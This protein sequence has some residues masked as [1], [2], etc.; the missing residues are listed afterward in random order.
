[1]YFTSGNKGWIQ[2][3]PSTAAQSVHVPASMCTQNTL[4]DFPLMC[5]EMGNGGNT[6]RSNMCRTSQNGC[7][8]PVFCV[9]LSAVCW[10]QCQNGGVCQRPNICSCPEG[11][12]GRLCEERKCLTATTQDSTLLTMVHNSE[13]IEL[14]AVLLSL[15]GSNRTLSNTVGIYRNCSLGD[16]LFFFAR[17]ICSWRSSLLI[18]NSY[19]HPAVPEWRPL[20]G[21]LPMRMSHR[22]DRHTLS[23]WWV[24]V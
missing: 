7:W 19:L 5:W 18:N 24:Q 10:L 17:L 20:R 15:T 14:K 3:G 11:W 4:R 13:T 23:Q 12:M 1:M 9:L 21:S 16:G 2:A 22:V 8:S 6:R